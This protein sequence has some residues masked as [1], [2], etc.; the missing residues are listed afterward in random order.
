MKDIQ[1]EIIQE[2]AT[3]S[4]TDS[5][6]TKEINLISWNGAKPKYDVRSWAPDREKCGKG[7]ALSEEEARN[8]LQALQ[9]EFLK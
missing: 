3:L 9:M 7:I 5:G 4:K 8:L 6:Y 2:I 1:F